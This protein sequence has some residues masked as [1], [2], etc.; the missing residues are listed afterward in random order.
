MWFTDASFL[1]QCFFANLKLKPEI[2]LCFVRA[3]TGLD[4]V[5]FR[6]CSEL[7]NAKLNFNGVLNVAN[8]HFVNCEWPEEHGRIKVAVEDESGQ[9]QATRDFYQRMKR[10]YKDEHNEYEASRWHIAEKEAQ[11]R[12]MTQNTTPLR[13]LAREAL[14]KGACHTTSKRLRR[15][16]RKVRQKKF[17]VAAR[18]LGRI[19]EQWARPKF[20]AASER[21]TRHALRTY[22]LLSGFGEKPVLALC[23]LLLFLLLPLLPWIFPGRYLFYIPLLREQPTAADGFWGVT[24]LWML[25]WQLLITF[26]AALFAF[27]LRNRF[28]R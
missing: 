2:Q 10:K 12:L 16:G 28:R 13:R 4:P 22:K 1:K 25:L 6:D 15:V 5:Y 9:L 21:L 11:L 14:G 7:R 3:I 24:R 8:L 23:W 17:G 18:L 19:A 20:D 27:A 26:Q